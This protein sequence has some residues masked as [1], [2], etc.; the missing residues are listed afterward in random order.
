MGISLGFSRQDILSFAEKQ[1][2]R[3]LRV[4]SYLIAAA[5]ELADRRLAAQEELLRASLLPA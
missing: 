1:Q 2:M 4:T 5:A 3:Y